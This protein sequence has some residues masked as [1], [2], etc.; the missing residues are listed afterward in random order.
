M[1]ADPEH[2]Y[3]FGHTA[4]AAAR[5]RLVDEVFTEPTRELL[6]VAG[7]GHV[8]LA[9]DLGCGPGFSTR[10]IA[11]TI[12]PARLVGLDV[13]E[14]F[15]EQAR[16]AGVAAAWIRHDVTVVPFPHGPADLLH[17][18]FVL[19]HLAQP[20]AVLVS[21]LSQLVPGG[22]LLVQEDEQIATDH[23]VLASYEEM[24]RSLVSHRGGDLW[25]GARLGTLEPPPG[26][27]AAV[28]RVHRHLVAVPLAARMY[29]MNFAVW[30]NEPFIIASYPVAELDALAADLDRLSGS[31]EPGH[32][33]FDIR[34]VAYT[35][36][37]P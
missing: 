31:S 11:E 23:P 17:A 18:R 36:Q 21:W 24:A 32:V 27:T 15:L 7:S 19:S 6:E 37:V 14:A 25:V 5:L 28:N 1:S 13:S 4:A 26:Y 16:A 35:R 8:D 29:A 3:A 12:Q 20:E 34:Q 30:R 2:R 9:V 22:H 10:L 33:I